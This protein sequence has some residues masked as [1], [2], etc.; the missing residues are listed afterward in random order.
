MFPFRMRQ[1]LMVLCAVTVSLMLSACSDDKKKPTD[2]EPDPEV[3]TVTENL[4]GKVRQNGTT[5][6]NFTMQNPGTI[7]LEL[8]RLEPLESI[9]MGMAIGNPDPAAGCEVFARDDSV[10]IFQTFVSQGQPAGTY[11]TCIFDVGNIFPDETIDFT[12][13][14]THPE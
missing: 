4:T 5:C 2:P 7:V 6:N 11:C 13:R 8:T 12:Q 14:V 1:R 3:P 9:T 10:R